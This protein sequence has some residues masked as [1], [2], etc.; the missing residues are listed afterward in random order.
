MIQCVNA[1]PGTEEQHYARPLPF[2]FRQQVEFLRARFNDDDTGNHPMDSCHVVE[3][4]GS[5]KKKCG[6]KF[7]VSI[8][9][10]YC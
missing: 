2:K 1:Q 10:M 5:R 3:Y 4:K 9:G 7:I 6:M 8:L